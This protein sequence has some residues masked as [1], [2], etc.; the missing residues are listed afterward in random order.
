MTREEWNKLTGAD[1]SVMADLE[2]TVFK[3]QCD[4]AADKGALRQQFEKRANEARLA[5]SAL[6]TRE[7]AQ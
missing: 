3:A 2:W 5:L 6:Y 1:D 4:K 7:C